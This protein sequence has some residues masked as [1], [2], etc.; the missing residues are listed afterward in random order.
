MGKFRKA[1]SII[2][3]LVII[4][5]VCTACN[6]NSV[7]FLTKT[8]DLNMQYEAEMTVQSGELEF[9]C[10]V[11]RFGTEFWE[12]SVSAPDTLSGLEIQ[13]N[14]DGVKATLDGLTLD[15]T[16][17]ELQ[18]RAVFALIFKAL[19]N[20]AANKLSCTDTEDGMYYEGD[21]GGT[22][23]RITFDGETL[24][25]V[26]LEIPEAAL[27]AEIKGFETIDEMEETENS[28]QAIAE[29]D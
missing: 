8:P 22:I 27:T 19:D 17:D 20:A 25:P 11:K 4:L 5:F 6:S 24:K 28:D 16:M 21:F 23:Y 7:N 12:M 3:L 18:D 26:L 13:M 9:S 15:M 1:V 14:S 2:L 29:T 10:R